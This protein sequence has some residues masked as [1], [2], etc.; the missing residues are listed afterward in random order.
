MY[1]F[2]YVKPSRSEFF[3][4]GF[5]SGLVLIAN[6]NQDDYS[7]QVGDLAGIRVVISDQNQLAFPEDEGITV[8]P[9]YETFLEME[10][11]GNGNAFIR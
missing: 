6:V 5:L 1:R 4:V 7:N 8:S 10:Q 2:R 3:K 9:G 11:V